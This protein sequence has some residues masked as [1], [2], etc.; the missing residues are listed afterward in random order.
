MHGCRLVFIRILT[1]VIM[2][3]SEANILRLLFLVLFLYFL[4]LFFSLRVTPRHQKR[5]LNDD[6]LHKDERLL[7]LRY[8]NFFLLS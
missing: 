3:G 7:S 4:F 6:R 8:A 5:T 2:A 1:R